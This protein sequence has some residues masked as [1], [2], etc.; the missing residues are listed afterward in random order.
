MEKRRA[1]SG[2]RLKRWAK[3]AG[4]HTAISEDLLD[5]VTYLV[6]FP[7]A[8]CGSIDDKYLKLPKEAVITPMR[9]HQRY[10][11]VLDDS[12]KLLPYFIT[13]RN[14]NSEHLDIVTHGNERVLRAR[15]DDAVF[16][17]ETTGKEP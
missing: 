13:V 4:G 6:E 3:K 10:F 8:L 1:S 9:D 5:E 2:N 15:L 7:T 11:P 12:G 17:F 14:G 16:F